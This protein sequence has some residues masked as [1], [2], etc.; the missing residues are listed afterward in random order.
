M[1][2]HHLSRRLT[3]LGRIYS[4]HLVSASSVGG[5][6]FGFQALFEAAKQNPV[7]FVLLVLLGVKL[8]LDLESPMHDEG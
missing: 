3:S 5:W 8:A 2:V 4:P 1:H 7:A 6:I